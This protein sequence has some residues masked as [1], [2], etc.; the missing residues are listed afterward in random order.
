MDYDVIIAGAGPA[1]LSVGSELSKELK[2]LVID[3]KEK[4]SDCHRSWLVPDLCVQ[5]GNAQEITQCA[6]NGVTHFL[7][8]TF[9]GAC[10]KW[11]ALLKYYFI[12]EHKVLPMWGDILESNGA[13]I[14]LGCLYQ[15]S[16]V[17]QDK[18]IVSTSEGTFTT[19]LLID[20]SGYNSPIRK[21]YNIMEKG[22][23]WWSVYGAI[24]EFPDGL[25]DMEVGDYMLW[26][27]FKDTNAHVDT[28]MAHGRPVLEYEI[29]DDKTAFVF[30]FYLRKNQVEKDMMHE[31]F[32]HVLRHEKSMKNYENCTIKEWKFGWYPMGGMNSQKVAEDRVTFIGDAG[33]W[34][35]PCGWGFSFVVDNYKKYAAN[36]LASINN[37]QFD[38]C[39]LVNLIQLSVRTKS[40]VLI[41][42][43][44]THFLANASAPMLD[45]FINLFEPGG[46]LGDKGPLLCEKLFTLT[47]SDDDVK[48]ML[49]VAVKY[50]DLRE[51]MHIMPHEDYFLLLEEVKEYVEAEV[52]DGLHELLSIFKHKKIRSVHINGFDFS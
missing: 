10:V 14:L 38:K 36:L 39:H 22:Y 42:Q 17:E 32:D 44:T 24:V 16:E 6:H 34:T 2:V 51:L 8:K 52:L 35:A 25:N 43:I 11:D 37:E 48:F 4:I 18:V 3:K 47:L 12:D 49:K 45:K 33:C 31:E 15:D 19:R 26:Q 40:Q 21:K 46:P 50:F 30:I 7:T 1:G 27:T 28:S 23:Y 29:L 41:D 20:A 5:G 9:G 13:K